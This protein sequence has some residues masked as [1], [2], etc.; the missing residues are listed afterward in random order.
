VKAGRRLMISME[1]DRKEDTQKE[2]WNSN[3]TDDKRNP[4]QDRFSAGNE[5]PFQVGVGS[6]AESAEERQVFPPGGCNTA[7]GWV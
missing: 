7:P 6:Q 1:G 3:P 2:W 4:G 5:P